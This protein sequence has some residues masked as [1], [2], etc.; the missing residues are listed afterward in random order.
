MPLSANSFVFPGMT[1]LAKSGITF[2]HA[3]KKGGL[4]YTIYHIPYGDFMLFLVKIRS[5]FLENLDVKHFQISKKSILT[6]TKS[7]GFRV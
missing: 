6:N 7:L 4:P 5:F 2:F 3:Q 1:I